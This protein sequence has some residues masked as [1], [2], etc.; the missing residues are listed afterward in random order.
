MFDDFPRPALRF[1]LGYDIPSCRDS[2]NSIKLLYKNMLVIFSLTRMRQVEDIKKLGQIAALQIM[3]NR[4]FK[5]FQWDF[6]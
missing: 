3:H 4:K 2:K 1:D 5:P 6:L